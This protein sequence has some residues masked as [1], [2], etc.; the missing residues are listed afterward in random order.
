MLSDACSLGLLGEDCELEPP[1]KT[2]PDSGVVVGPER[3]V[4]WRVL[5]AQHFGVA[6]RRKRV[7]VVASARA[8][9]DPAEVLFE[10]EGLRRDIAPVRDEE[11]AFARVTAGTDGAGCWWDGGQISQT[12]DAVLHKG[13]MMPEKN[14]FPAVLQ[15][16]DGV[17]R[18]RKATPVECERLQGF[19]DNHTLV[20]YRGK[21]MSDTQRLKALGNSMA[22]LVMHWLGHRIQLVLERSTHARP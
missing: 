1:G 2:W 7:F 21:P 15:V 3:T 12:L 13:Q 17:V 9:F 8:G 6:Q 19:P 5:N 22:V 4:V 18:V 14:R 11:E 20:P 10:C 16:V